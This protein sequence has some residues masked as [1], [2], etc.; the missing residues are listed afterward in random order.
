M[1]ALTVRRTPALV[2]HRYPRRALDGAGDRAAGAPLV[3]SGPYRWFAHPNY[4]AVIVEGAA[5]PLT[6]VGVDHRVR[7]HG[8][9]RRAADRA[10]PVRGHGPGRGR[11]AG[12]PGVMIDVLVVGGGP[13]GLA[14][15]IRCA[16]A[17]LSVDGRRAPDG[18]RRQG[19]RRGRHARRGAAARGPRRHAG[20]PSAARHPL[21]RRSAP[22]RRAF[23]ARG[24]PRRPPHGAARRPR[25]ARRRARHPGPPGP[26]DRVRAACRPRDRRRRG[27]PVPGGGRRAALDDPPHPG[28]RDTRRHQRQAPPGPG[29]ALRAS[30]ALPRRAVDGLG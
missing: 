8:A 24:R 26:G 2:V 15:A 28:T 29:A 20:R 25:R 6:G 12:R 17:G 19:L 4:V 23:Q 7:V 5:L 18:P 1:L 3:R 9:Q 16:L 11:P 13:V 22:G 27:G 14:T 10:H 21:P 30:Q